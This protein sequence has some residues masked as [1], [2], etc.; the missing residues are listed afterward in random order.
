M[1]FKLFTGLCAICTY[2][3]PLYIVKP[4]R[5]QTGS[6]VKV[7]DL[8]SVY[9]I[10]AL[11]LILLIVLIVFS[12]TH[13]DIFFLLFSL[14]FMSHLLAILTYIRNNLA[15][16]EGAQHGRISFS[17]GFWIA[18]LTIYML[19]SWAYRN[20]RHKMLPAA[21]VALLIGG[22][23]L[24]TLLGSFGHSAILLEFRSRSGKFLQELLNHVSL[25][26]SAVGTATLLGIPAG[27]WAA[28]S[29][30]YRNLIFKVVNGVQTIPSL[31]L[32]GLMIAPLALISRQ[33]PVLRSLGIAGVGNTP[34]LIA[35]S[36]YSLLPIIRNTFTG[37][38]Y[39][40]SHIISAATGM[41]MSKAQRFRYVELPLATPMMLT[42]IRMSLVQTT[43][44]TAV[45]AL[46]GAGGLGT[47]IF[48]GLGQSVPDLILLGVIPVILLSILFDRLF[49]WAEYIVTPKGVRIS[50]ET[51]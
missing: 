15:L 37:I 11:I 5:I 44:N 27:I 16:W 26:L 40:E 46:I 9:W 18:L 35:L 17:A 43:G 12:R 13:T 1:R 8:P 31:A 2:L 29:E 45:A 48:Q 30:K 33:F 23:A 47:F 24:F 34:A 36:L 25:S 50:W 38:Y 3:L 21:A 4:N 22:I 51:A 32:F 41:G 39:I 19:L 42:G 20:T 49:H 6:A 14:A 10:G 7:F 28:R